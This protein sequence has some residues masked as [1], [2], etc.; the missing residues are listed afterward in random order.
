VTGTPAKP[1]EAGLMGKR[2][3]KATVEH[4]MHALNA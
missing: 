1:S 3:S 2:R 4:L